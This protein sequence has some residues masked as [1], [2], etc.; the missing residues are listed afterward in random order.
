METLLRLLFELLAHAAGLLLRATGNGL[1]RMFSFGR[2]QV[3]PLFPA[4]GE[5]TPLVGMRTW[6]GRL[7]AGPWT[8]FLIGLLFWI[9]AVAG[10]ARLAG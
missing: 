1:I 5:R 7:V 9:V 2:V 8:S 3:A 6:Q 10:L 4:R